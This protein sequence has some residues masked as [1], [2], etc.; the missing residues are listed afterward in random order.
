MKVA[1]TLN[2]GKMQLDVPPNE[3]L[4]DTLRNRMGLTGTKDV[5]RTGDCGACTVLMNGKAVHSCLT[6]TVEAEGTEVVTIEGLEESG[7]SP[8]QAAFLEEEA[9]HC[10]FCTP[11][12]IMSAT[13][14]LKTNPTPTEREVRDALEGNLCRCGTY[15]GDVAA[16]LRASRGPARK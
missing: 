5:C 13:A 7:L 2:R 3:V 9:V 6:L 4:L 8:V 10:G 1:L 11:G 14:L 15:Y 12:M 16:V